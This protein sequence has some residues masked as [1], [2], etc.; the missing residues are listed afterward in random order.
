MVKKHMH[1]QDQK[2]YLEIG[3]YGNKIVISFQ[4]GTM[5]LVYY[6]VLLTHAI[7]E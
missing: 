5:W 3:N 2:E 1:Y 6:N 4:Q 7:I